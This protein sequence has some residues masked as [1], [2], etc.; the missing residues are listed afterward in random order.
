MSRSRLLECCHTY[1]T[2]GITVLDNHRIG[3]NRAKLRTE[4]VTD[5]RSCLQQATPRSVFGPQPVYPL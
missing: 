4:Q 1:R 3:G 2:A 5:L